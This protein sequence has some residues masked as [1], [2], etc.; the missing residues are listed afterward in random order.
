[1]ATNN[2]VLVIGEG[3]TEFYYFN[4]LKDLF[5]QTQL[6]PSTPKHSNLLELEKRIK[7]GIASGFAKIYCVID[8]DNK[9]GK[10]LSKYNSIKQRYSNKIEHP[11]KGISCSVHFVETHRCTELF[12]L[13]YFKYTTKE[14]I[15][16]PSL[17]NELNKC[18][19]YRKE[20]KFFRGLKGGLHAYFER[21]GGALVDAVVRSKKSCCEIE[22][23]IGTGSYS[24]ME[25]LFRAL[26]EQNNVRL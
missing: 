26:M 24:Q 15:N 18:C 2:S 19:L 12:F 5:P 25:S 11:K 22:R 6:E 17:L 8:M 14:F 21:N 7:E 23:R 3:E 16:Q 9:V 10:E 1:M 20:V 13:Y 4:S